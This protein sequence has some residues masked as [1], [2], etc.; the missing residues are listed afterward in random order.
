MK[1]PRKK[2]AI[3]IVSVCL[4]IAILC[5]LIIMMRH[6]DVGELSV[7]DGKYLFS[8]SAKEEKGY[9]VI[10]QAG[11]R[12]QFFGLDATLNKF[13]EEI[14]RASIHAMKTQMQENGEEFTKEEED[15]VRNSTIDYKSKI[16][17]Q[18]IAFVLEEANLIV[19]M[20]ELDNTVLGNI[21]FSYLP[22][23]DTII[24]DDYKYALEK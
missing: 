18:S 22:R 11:T 12:I 4:F 19:P 5:A 8:G 17:E 24:V 3:I 20:W 16:G 1:V 23:E 10:S 2:T 6:T 15:R 7:K 21:C 14:E 9:V 13:T